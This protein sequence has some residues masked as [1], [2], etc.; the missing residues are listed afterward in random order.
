MNQD[1]A[2]QVTRTIEA[3]LKK[4]NARAALLCEADGS[5]VAGSGAYSNEDR[6]LAMD[7]APGVFPGTKRMAE[8]LNVNEA[9]MVSLP[10]DNIHILIFWVAQQYFFLIFYPAA[11]NPHMPPQNAV[12]ACNSIRAIIQPAAQNGWKFWK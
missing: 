12:E 1:Q 6:K 7:L 10:D 4:S 9:Q 11:V 3:F 2:K 5:V 8:K